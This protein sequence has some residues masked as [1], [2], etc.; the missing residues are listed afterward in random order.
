MYDLQSK[1]DA[2]V[3]PGLQG[4]PHENTIAAMAV[5]MA[6]AK[7]TEFVEYQRQVIANAQAMSRRLKEHGYAISTGKL[8]AGMARLVGQG[9]FWSA[10]GSRQ[11][12]KVR[13]RGSKYGT[14]RQGWSGKLWHI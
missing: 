8:D 1:I 5:A 2:A 9:G 13:F 3:F 7:T 4:G 10:I 6:Q 14:S 12:V 11:E